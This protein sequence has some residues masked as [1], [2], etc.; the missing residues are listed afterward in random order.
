MSIFRNVALCT[1]TISIQCRNYQWNYHLEKRRM[2]LKFYSITQKWTRKCFVGIPR[3]LDLVIVNLETQSLVS[4]SKKT[5]QSLSRVLMKWRI[6][7][8]WKGTKRAEELIN[9][10]ELIKIFPGCISI[11]WSMWF[12]T[13]RIF[14]TLRHIKTVLSI[15][16][17]NFCAI[18]F[19]QTSAHE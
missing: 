14:F 10:W 16:F 19:F 6:F 1:R 5:F 13:H 12:I 18:F 9:W 2:Q 4:I 15:S 17:F 3:C 7:L 11:M 8:C